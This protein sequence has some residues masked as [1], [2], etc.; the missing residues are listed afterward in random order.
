MSNTN[1]DIEIP[2]TYSETYKHYIPSYLVAA[3]Y[4][5]EYKWNGLVGGIFGPASYK[6]VLKT[7]WDYYVSF[8]T[9]SETHIEANYDSGYTVSNYNY[10]VNPYWNT[11]AGVSIPDTGVFTKVYFRNPQ[12]SSVTFSTSNCSVSVQ[13]NTKASFEVQFNSVGFAANQN[14]KFKCSTVQKNCYKQYEWTNAVVY[15]KKSTD[16]SYSTANATVSG[17]WSDVTVST[18]NVTLQDNYIYDVYITATADDGTTAST[19]VGQF[20]TVDADAVA[21][22]ISPSGAFISG[23][24]TFVWSHATEYGTPQYAYDLQ[25][26]TNNGG[27]WTT[28]KSHEVTSSTTTSITLTNSGVYLWRVRTY[29][30]NNVVGDW[31]E[32]SFVNQVPVTPPINLSVNTKGRP[33]VTWASSS[34]SAYQIQ[35]VLNDFNVVYDSG[36]VYSTETSHFVNKYFDDSRA[37][38]VKLRIYDAL[39]EVSDWVST[40][41]QQPE[42][43]DVEFNVENNRVG[44]AKITVTSSDE[45]LKYYLLRND[46]VIAKIDAEEEYVDK[47][48]IGITNYSVVGVTSSDQSDIKSKGLKVTYPKATIVTLEGQVIAINKR[49]DNVYEVK[50]SVSA[51]ISSAKF[52]GDSTPTHY[53]SEMRVKSFTVT[54]FDDQS[55]AESL[56]GNVV[57]YADN[58]GNGGY[59]MVTNYSKSDDFLKY[60]HGIYSNDTTLTLEVTNYEDSIEYPI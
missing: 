23:N 14:P 51:N 57:F 49:V 10:P 60:Q 48:A 32:A 37:Y 1:Y 20:N 21:T 45:F 47:Y 52:I 40:G 42:I 22:C 54:F 29:N 31:G 35:F 58:Y 4:Y 25:Y 3:P 56:L 11:Y 13:Y 59:C 34:Q 43:E 24:C 38:T 46:K 12:R 15:Y 2:I 44:G 33:T 26:S 8:D 7:A 6:Y 16:T 53:S 30:S 28:V 27:S 50:T 9:G 39:G 18:S 19:S 55:I 41:Y 5:Y 17:T 36:A